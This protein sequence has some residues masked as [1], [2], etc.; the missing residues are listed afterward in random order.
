MREEIATAS[1]G[2][3]AAARGCGCRGRSLV[4]SPISGFDSR[5]QLIRG[6]G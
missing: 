2:E 4:G 6:R 1:G 5:D 3:A